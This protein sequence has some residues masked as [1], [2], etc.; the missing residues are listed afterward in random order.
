MDWSDNQE[1]RAIFREE[2]AD[3]SRNLVEGGKALGGGEFESGVLNDLARDGHTIKGNALVMGFPTIAEAGKLLEATW[4]ELRDGQRQ[5]D[6]EL[7]ALLARLA[8]HLLPAVDIEGRAEPRELL[9][10]IAALRKHLGG[11]GDDTPSGGSPAGSSRPIVQGPGPTVSKPER[12]GSGP[13]TSVLSMPRHDVSSPRSGSAPVVTDGRDPVDLGGLLSTI[14][15]R[16]VADVTRVD[17]SKLYELINRSVEVKL[18]MEALAQGLRGL[19]MAVAAGPGEVAAL[20]FT[21]ESSVERLEESLDDL[22]SQ[23]LDL[24]TVPLREVTDTFPQ[25]VNY[26]G[27][28]TGKELRFELIGDDVE[29]DRQIVDALREPLRH[30]LVNAVDHGIESP[31]E[32]QE[33]GKKPI[34][35]ISI[36]AKVRDHKLIITVEDDGRGVNWDRVREVAEQQSDPTATVSGADLGRMLFTSGFST[37]VSRTDL[38]G[39]G[40]GLASVSEMTAEM[41]GGMRLDT[42]PGGGTVVV[43]TL[44]ASL[45]M[46]DVLLVRSDGHRW[47]IPQVALLATFPISAGEIR[48]GS[49]RMELWYQGHALP[50]S[51]FAS[52]VGLP[53]LEEPND[54]VVLSTRLGPV[55]LTVPQ[56]DGRR[57]VAVKG[58]GPVL[59]GSPHLAGAALLGGGQVVVVVDPDELGDRVRAVPRPVTNRPRVLVVDDS[60]GV[61]QLV[62]AALSGQGFDV[63]VASSANEAERELSDSVFDALVV[64]YQ[65]P[66]SDGIELVKKVRLGSQALPVIMVS[67]VATPEDQD[68][69][70]KAGVDAYLD[71][72]DLRKGAL[73]ETLR[74]LLQMRGVEFEGRSA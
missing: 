42:T 19:R 6:P 65:M 66:D 30:L 16:I 3:R 37:V 47:G 18:D 59:A 20:A 69:A 21:W 14:E 35:T 62:G 8:S 43:I 13:E 57:E 61:R 24:A 58:L 2:V 10:S 50:L 12:G 5:P 9:A 7:G 32:R 11:G 39:D 56:V 1:L 23:A 64:D 28:R 22:Q 29:V 54:V 36:R 46:Q 45:A 27:R 53:E 52:A 48:P 60:Q 38:S 15:G 31:E 72:F 49:D 68:R 67:A 34:A 44:P 33:A 70:W 51:S 74:S 25:L 73:V 40:L 4:K 71:K 63:V 41:N 26:L 55:A 17:S